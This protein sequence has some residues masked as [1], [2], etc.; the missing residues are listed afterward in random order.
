[1]IDK[2]RPSDIRCPAVGEIDMK[3]RIAV[4]AGDGIGQEVSAEGLRK[5]EA[6]MRRGSPRA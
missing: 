6:A 2:L 4:I 5:L 1:M 3:A